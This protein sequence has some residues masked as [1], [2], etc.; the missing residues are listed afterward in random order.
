MIS[1]SDKP[2]LSQHDIL[3]ESSVLTS[4]IIG[5]LW[6]KKKRRNPH[7]RPFFLNKLCFTCFGFYTPLSCNTHSFFSP[8]F[9]ENDETG[10]MD[11]LLE[12][13]QSGAAFRDRRKRA[14]RPRGKS[15]FHKHTLNLVSL[16]TEQN[17]R[18]CFDAVGYLKNDYESI[19][20][21]TSGCIVMSFVCC[22][23]L[24]FWNALIF[25]IRG[26]PTVD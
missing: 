1:R 14:P 2:H 6:K 19:S 23:V 24:F 7:L 15:H 20:W 22:F 11:S 18:N 21:V 13:L 12:A 5:S 17:C 3:F 26:R 25:N 8:S 10:V 4:T 16:M 9:S